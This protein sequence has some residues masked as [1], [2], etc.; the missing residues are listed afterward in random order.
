MDH[1]GYVRSGMRASS[2]KLAGPQKN[3]Y[4]RLVQQHRSGR[5]RS[6]LNHVAQK[7]QLEE[8]GLSDT[9]SDVDVSL[10]KGMM[11][12]AVTRNGLNVPDPSPNKASLSENPDCVEAEEESLPCDGPEAFR[13]GPA[14]TCSEARQSGPGEPEEAGGPP[15]AEGSSEVENL[16]WA[17]SSCSLAQ[18]PKPSPSGQKAGASHEKDVPETGHQLQA[19]PSASHVERAWE[20]S[21]AEQQPPL[22]SSSLNSEKAGPLTPDQLPG[23]RARKGSELSSSTPSSL[24]K[25]RPLLESDAMSHLDGKI[26]PKHLG[27]PKGASHA[28]GCSG[29]AGSSPGDKKMS[30]KHSQGKKRNIFEAYMSRE[31]VSAGL[32]R[33]ALIQGVLRINPK[34]YHEA[35]IPSPDGTRDIFIDGV[36]ARNRALNGDLVVVELLPKDRWKMK[37][38]YG[39]RK[40]VASLSKLIQSMK[41]KEKNTH[42]GLRRK[43]NQAA[44]LLQLALVL[45]QLKLE[46]GKPKTFWGITQSPVWVRVVGWGEYEI[47]LYGNESQYLVKEFGINEHDGKEHSS[48][49]KFNFI[50][51]TK[52]RSSPMCYY[53]C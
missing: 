29:G 47:L 15:P 35:F 44:W 4:A 22:D 13:K 25:R 50:R 14:W 43:G 1:L 45:A 33:G 8:M 31:N 21:A 11:R 39:S 20:V 37:E 46:E 48:I 40:D 3:A 28:V 2:S 51:L 36:V 5:F 18:S 52:G 17:L 6:Y 26:H 49:I 9:G 19:S 10:K 30:G 41:I 53:K 27:T 34:K 24:G 38:T 32:K 42:K 12:E 16:G 7:M 23:S